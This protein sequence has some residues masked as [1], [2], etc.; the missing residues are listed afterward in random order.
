MGWLFPLLQL[1]QRREQEFNWNILLNG[2]SHH[3]WT[4]NTS[5]YIMSAASPYVSER[6]L[7]LKL[8][9]TFWRRTCKPRNAATTATTTTMTMTLTMKTT[10]TTTTTKSATTTTTA[11]PT[12]MTATTTTTTTIT[13]ATTTT[14]TAA[15][16]MSRSTGSVTYSPSA[17]RDTLTRV[18]STCSQRVVAVVVVIAWYTTRSSFI[19]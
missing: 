2:V 3:Q 16:P 17:S 1:D 14:T 15:T 4:S 5:H 10:M 19:V 13:T 8:S 6:K 11:T 18:A 12:T 9:K 7:K